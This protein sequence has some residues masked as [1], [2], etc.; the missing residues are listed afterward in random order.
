MEEPA[1]TAAAAAA[2]DPKAIISAEFPAYDK[3]ANQSLSRAEFDG[4]LTALKDKAGEKPMRPA[5]KTAWL[6]AAFA[7]ADKDKSKSVTMAE[8]TDYLTAAG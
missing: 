6:K 5:D 7:T 8:L 4:W 2:T 1:V 3:D